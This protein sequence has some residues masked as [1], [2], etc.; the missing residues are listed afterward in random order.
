MTTNV[1][2]G[3]SAAVPS[4]ETEGAVAPSCYRVSV[5]SGSLEVSARL[6]SADDLELLMKV[7]EANKGLF[8]K[9]ERSATETVVKPTKT[10]A[11]ADGSETDGFA[12]ADRETKSSATVDRIANGI[13]TP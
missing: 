4:P 13:L 10:S 2:R 9:V 6:K 5:F 12:K 1:E 3:G 11:T 7:L 8:P